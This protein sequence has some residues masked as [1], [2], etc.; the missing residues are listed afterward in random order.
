MNWYADDDMWR[1]FYH[2]MFDEDSFAE[3]A[4]QCQAMLNWLDAPPQ[5]VLDAACGPGRHLC[6]FAQLGLQV[7]GVD[8]SAYL[9][10]QARQRLER[11]GLAAQLTQSDLLQHRP[12]QPVHLITHLFNSF[13]Y[14]AD[15]SDNRAVLKR[16]CDWLEPGGHLVIDVFS[17]ELLARSIE[18]V[19]LTEYDNGDVRIERPILIDD[20][21]RYSNEWMLVR[22]DQVIRWAYSH[23][24]YAATELQAALRDAGFEVVQTFGNFDGDAYDLDAERLIVLARKV[25][26]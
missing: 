3:A 21:S 22:G 12:Q 25:A 2:C 26:R 24:V 10:A 1:D 19:H 4:E 7:Q 15:E 17:K 5:R 20:M 14:Y 9:L 13:G 18:P 6:G 8:L 16:F 11:Q 23:A